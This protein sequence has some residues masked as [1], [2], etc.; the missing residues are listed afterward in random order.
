MDFQDSR[1]LLEWAY[2]LPASLKDQSFLGVEA[3]S[4][5]L[6]PVR[7][8]RTGHFKRPDTYPLRSFLPKTWAMPSHSLPVLWWLFK[9]ALH[10][11]CYRPCSL[12][13]VKAPCVRGAFNFILQS[14]FSKAALS[15]R[16][17]T[18]HTWL[19][20]FKLIKTEYNLKINSSIIFQVLGSHTWVEM[21]A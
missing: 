9:R 17:A 1:L 4:S 18:S 11:G 3:S 8:I 5:Y 6:I 13:V 14:L 10:K 12:G 19:F 15:D 21:P 16:V 20:K 7:F 2:S